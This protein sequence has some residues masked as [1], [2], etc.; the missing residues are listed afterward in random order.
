MC[1]DLI[2]GLVDRQG[3]VINN[4]KLFRVKVPTSQTLKP[5]HKSTSSKDFKVLSACLYFISNNNKKKKDLWCTGV[6][7]SSEK[8]K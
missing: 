8:E 3:A 7:F 5:R 4:C 1:L 6:N 2:S